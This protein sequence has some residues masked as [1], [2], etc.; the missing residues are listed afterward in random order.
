MTTRLDI[1]LAEHPEVRAL[2]KAADPSY[3]RKTAVVKVADGIRLSRTF[4]DG[5]SRSTYTAVD[6]VTRAAV[7]AP[8]FA[9]P[10]F[11]GP[12]TPPTVK[13]P[14]NICVVETGVFCGKVSQAYVYVRPE[15]MAALLVQA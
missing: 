4:W 7:D 2:I 13:L 9:P 14:P 6:M 5:G 10:Q 8:Q 3:R 11:G 12:T 1:N 15:N